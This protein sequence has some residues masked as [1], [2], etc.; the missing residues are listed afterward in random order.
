MGSEIGADLGVSLEG[1]TD[2]E[3]SPAGGSPGAPFCC[4]GPEGTPEG[5]GVVP[6]IQYIAS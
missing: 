1:P 4:L 2:S 5:A 6:K 3:G